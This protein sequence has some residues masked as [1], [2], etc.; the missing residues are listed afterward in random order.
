MAISP[1]QMTYL[2]E[3]VREVYLG[4]EYDILKMIAKKTSEGID[5]PDWQQRKLS[6]IQIVLREIEKL[7]ADAENASAKLTQ[8]IIEESFMSGIKSAENDYIKAFGSLSAFF[9]TNMNEINNI[10]IT[11]LIAETNNLIKSMNTQIL[12]KAND[13]YRQVVSNTSTKVIGGVLTKRQAIKE[14]L[15]EFAD[16]GISGFVD[17]AGRNW[18]LAS[19]TDMALR[20]SIGRASMVGHETRLTQLNQDLVIVSYHPHSCKLCDSYEGK[21]LSISGI[22]TKYPSLAQAKSN[23]LFHANCGHV[24]TLY[25]EGFTKPVEPVKKIENKYDEKQKQRALERDV[26]RWKRMEA[27]A[28]DEQSRMIAQNKIKEK[29]KQLRDIV[30]EN[31]FKRR[32][33]REQINL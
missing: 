24:A 18:N 30:K 15:N 9:G 4:L 19:Y 12:R 2:A 27:V 14:S 33:D 3:K 10:A 26:R 5:A 6:E 7:I 31:D 17:R 29:Q 32:Y 28:S 11:S 13:S 22:S 25:V 8:D 20:T 23:G 21:V 1:E 16:K